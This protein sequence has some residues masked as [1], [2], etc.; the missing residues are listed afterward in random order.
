[1]RP[2]HIETGQKPGAIP[3]T[4]TH[5]EALGSET[6][7]IAT[8]ADGHSLQI[9]VAADQ[10]VEIGSTLQISF[11]LPLIHLFD[12]VTELAIRP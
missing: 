12:P 5:L 3:A 7:V 2:E 9:R 10:P 11:P 6:F 4:V 8:L 1:I